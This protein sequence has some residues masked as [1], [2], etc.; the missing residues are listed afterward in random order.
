MRGPKPLTKYHYRPVTANTKRTSQDHFHFAYSFR[1]Q[2]MT[3]TFYN[4]VHYEFVAQDN[5]LFF[6]IPCA[7]NITLTDPGSCHA[8]LRWWS[9]TCFPA[10]RGN[11]LTKT[12]TIPPVDILIQVG[13]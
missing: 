11:W 10:I 1:L 9:R 7:R 6:S 4:G 2:H 12:H 5:T 3:V 13:T 8:V